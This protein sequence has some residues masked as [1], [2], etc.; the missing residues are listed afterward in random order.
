[1]TLPAPLAELPLLAR[2]GTAARAAAPRRR[3][4]RRLRRRRAGGRRWPSAA[5]GRVLLAFPRGTLSAQLEDG[6]RLRSSEGWGGWR[7]DVDSHHERRWELQASLGTLRHPF[8]PCS[9][10]LDG[11]RLSRQDWS[12]EGETEVLRVSFLAREGKLVASGCSRR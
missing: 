10:V 8:S 3:H 11:R 7:L 9:V 6:G 2:A 1:M 5:T 12:Y 4:A